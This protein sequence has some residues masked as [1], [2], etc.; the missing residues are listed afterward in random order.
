M[1]DWTLPPKKS[2]IQCGMHSN[3]MGDGLTL[4]LYVFIKFLQEKINFPNNPIIL[5]DKFSSD[6][7]G[8]EPKIWTGI[9]LWTERYEKVVKL[10]H[11]AV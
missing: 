8:W 11:N 10:K 5:Q 1:C 4:W 6:S 3:W 7:D 2:D 9:S